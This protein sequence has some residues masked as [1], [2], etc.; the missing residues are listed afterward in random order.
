MHTGGNLVDEHI[1]DGGA[2]RIQ[3]RYGAAAA[4]GCLQV[5]NGYF[6]NHQDQL[7]SLYSCAS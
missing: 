6:L 7:L 1:F 2:G 5:N 3:E 4:G